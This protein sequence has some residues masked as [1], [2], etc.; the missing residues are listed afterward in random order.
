MSVFQLPK[1]LC[2][3]INS[4]MSHFWWGHKSNMG[5]IAWMS[6]ERFGTSKQSGGM[7]FWDLEIFNKALLA[8]QGWRLISSPDS[9]LARI[10]KE[11]YYPHGSFLEARL[12]S[13]PSFAWRS[14]L[15]AKPLVENGVGWRVGNGASIKI[16]GDAWLPPP[17]TRL[18]Q[19]PIGE[20]RPE[21]WVEALIDLDLGGWN[22]DLLHRLFAPEDVACIG[23]V[24]IS[25]LGQLDKLIWTGMHSGIFSVKSACHM[26][27]KRKAQE[28]G[29]NSGEK[30]SDEIWNL[31]WALKAPPVLK[32][33]CWKVA[34][35]L[36][37]TM[38]NLHKRKIVQNSFCP[39][40]SRDPENSFHSLWICPAAV[41]IWQE[42]N[43]R[44]QK[45][46]CECT[47]GKGL[48]LYFFEQLDPG[49]MM[50]VLAMARLVWLRRND[51]V[52]GRGLTLPCK[53]I[54]VVKNSL[55]CFAQSHLPESGSHLTP[56]PVMSWSKPTEGK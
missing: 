10:L 31:I 4:L 17:Y 13:R 23:S 37:P 18:L 22:L 8:K 34:N 43:R 42:S 6:W 16:W 47:D 39:I 55:D 51:Y 24:V 41:S 15:G 30:G 29:E 11:K 45:L 54:V 44:F 35:E 21:A 1:A 9:L 2:K 27:V 14:I 40:C 49:D 50:E 56:V 36:L 48:L 38:L 7:G 53:V 20:L 19:P 5:R 32:I 52:F 46:S 12:G 25:P 26:E 3:S 33:F 28:I